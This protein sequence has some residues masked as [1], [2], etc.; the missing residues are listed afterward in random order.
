MVDVKTDLKVKCWVELEYNRIKWRA[1]VNTVM[2]LGVPLK[3]WGSR[4]PYLTQIV[5]R[6]WV[7]PL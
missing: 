3:F 6:M 5:Y 4:V 1:F 7:L 2:N